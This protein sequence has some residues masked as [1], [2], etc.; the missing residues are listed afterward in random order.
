M[1]ARRRRDKKP[2]D[3]SLAWVIALCL[4]AGAALFAYSW[5]MGYAARHDLSQQRFQ[6]AALIV[7]GA[8]AIA[9][10]GIALW[11]GQDWR[12]FI[13]YPVG[14]AAGLLA[15][16]IAVHLG[17]EYLQ[18]HY[19]TDLEKFLLTIGPFSAAGGTFW[20]VFKGVFRLL[21]GDSNKLDKM[22]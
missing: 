5:L 13:A 18:E 20:P 22:L 14:L 2:A 6:P 17:K 12:L 8:S 21:R 10:G 7:S 1:S 4:G 16:V 3:Q 9:V 11:M 15:W 19:V